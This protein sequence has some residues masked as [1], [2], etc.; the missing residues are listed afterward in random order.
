MANKK[1]ISRITERITTQT[2]QFL[3]CNRCGRNFDVTKMTPEA[4]A[5]EGWTLHKYDRRY[6][7]VLVCNYCTAYYQE[8]S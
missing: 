6:E 7:A 4:I 3:Q 1:L 8:N 2:K 5:N